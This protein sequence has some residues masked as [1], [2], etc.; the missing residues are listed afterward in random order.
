MF[1]FSSWFQQF[2]EL[3]IRFLADLQQLSSVDANQ[4]L[5]TLAQQIKEGKNG[6]ERAK[7]AY[8]EAVQ[9]Y[10]TK[11]PPQFSDNITESLMSHRNLIVFAL[12]SGDKTLISTWGINNLPKNLAWIQDPNQREIYVNS[13]KDIRDDNSEQQEQQSGQQ[14][15]QSRQQ[16]SRKQKYYNYLINWL[17]SNHN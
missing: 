12:I 8:R 4:R 7:E 6:I 14:E 11:F 2:T 17:E 1:N 9:A 16:E 13:L 10:L 5:E 15:Q 3:C